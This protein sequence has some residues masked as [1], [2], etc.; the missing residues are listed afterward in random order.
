M[1]SWLLECMMSLSLSYELMTGSKKSTYIDV[2]KQI[3]AKN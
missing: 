1:E 3:K 2:L